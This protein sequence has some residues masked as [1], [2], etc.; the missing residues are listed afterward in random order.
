MFMYLNKEK[1]RYRIEA[2]EEQESGEGFTLSVTEQGIPQ[3]D[4]L[5]EEIVKAGSLR[6]L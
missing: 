4:Q 1:D 2:G 5:I 3:A 6:R